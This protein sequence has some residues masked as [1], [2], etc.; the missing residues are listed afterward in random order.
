VSLYNEAPSGPIYPTPVV[1]IVGRLP[2]ATRAGRLGF[3]ADGDLIAIVGPFD[4]SLAGSELAKLRGAAPEGPLP[5]ID[6]ATVRS[7]HQRVR[8]SV[9]SGSFVS[10]H[11][12]AEGGI[13]VALA[14]CCMAGGIGA[15]VELPAGVEPFGEAPGQG[16]LVSGRADDLA[17]LRVIGRVGGSELSIEGVLSAPVTELQRA[18]S[19]GLE[20]FGV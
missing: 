11:D 3:A 7:A 1:G 6:A 9:R 17:G 10:A 5:P 18:W 2:D 20:S 14:E 12:I 13:A 16:F 4:P 15:T 19:G 8:D